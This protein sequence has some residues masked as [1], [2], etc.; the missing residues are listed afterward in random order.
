MSA[1]LKEV[2]KRMRD[3]KATLQ[4]RL[5]ALDGAIEAVREI[6]THEWMGCGHD[7]HHNYVEC[8]HCGK[9]EIR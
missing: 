5:K 8:V 3:E 6:C 9:E 7:S 2:V 1:D 4:K